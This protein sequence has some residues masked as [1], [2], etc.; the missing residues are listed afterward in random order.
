LHTWYNL[1]IEN[2]H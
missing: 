1:I 2:K